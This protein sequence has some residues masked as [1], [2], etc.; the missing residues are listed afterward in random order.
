MLVASCSGGDA[1]PEQTD[2]SPRADPLSTPAPLPPQVSDFPALES[3]DCQVVAQFYL[4][5]IE[6]GA[7]ARAALV[8]ND[9]VID[10]DRLKALYSGYGRPKTAIREVT[11]EGAAGSLYCTV[12]GTLTDE[13]DPAKAPTE[14]QL[15]LRRVND[16]PGA[17][18]SQL[19]WTLIRSTFI[20]PMERSGRN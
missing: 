9:P 8:W 20:E 13:A 14:G 1:D 3:R 18:P 4:A 7:F 11:Q 19:R 17:T 2:G 6:D 15:E 12:P 16:V 5:A 10:A